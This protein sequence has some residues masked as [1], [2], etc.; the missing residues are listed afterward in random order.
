M[1]REATIASMTSLRSLLLCALWSFSAVAGA[2]ERVLSQ[3][4]EP[5]PVAEALEALGRQTG[6]QFIFVSSIAHAQRSKGAPAGLAPDAALA[7]LLDGTGLTFEFLNARTVRIFPAS[8]TVPT[9]AAPLPAPHHLSQRSALALEEVTVTATRREEVASRVPIDMMVWTQDAMEASGV[10]GMADLASLTPTMQFQPAPGTTGATTYLL[11]RGVTGRNASTTGVY[12]D[13]T[14]V[15]PLYGD[16]VLYSF[17]FTF[18]LDRVEVLRGPQLQLF[19]EGNQGGAVRFIFNQPSLST[20]TA[21]AK[22]ELATTRFGSPSYEA[23]A[24]FGGP[25]IRDAVGFRISAWARSDGGYVDRVDPFTQGV[26]DGNAN[27]SGSMS[28]RGAL[29]FAP[30]EAVQITPS[31][32]YT[33]YERHDQPYFFINLSDVGAGQLMNGSLL[34]QPANAAFYLGALKVAAVLGGVHFSAVSSYFNRTGY[35]LADDTS[36]FDWGSPL[37]SGYPVSYADA[38]ADQWHFQQRMFM[39]ELRL[40][41]PDPNATLT[42]H[43]GAFYSTYHVRWADHLTGTNGV[44]GLYPAP[45]DLS[46]VTS[47]AQTRLAVFG[48]VALRMTNRLAVS[49][50]V[51]GERT[52]YD[53]ENELAPLLSAAGADSGVMPR[54]RLAYQADEHELFYL[55]AGKGYGSGGPVAPCFIS[56]QASP[57][58]FGMDTLWSYEVGTKSTLLD[59]RMRLDTGLFHITWNNAGYLL[60]GP[61]GLPGSPGAAA[62]NGFDLAMQMLPSAHLQLDVDVAYTDARYTGTITQGGI[63]IVREGQAVN[64]S[65]DFVSVSPWTLTASVDYLVPLSNDVT[66]D[67]RAQDVFRSQNPGPFAQQDPQSPLY[68]PGYRPDPATNLVNLRASVRGG[69]YEAALFV[70]NAF[71]SLPTIQRFNATGVATTDRLDAATF[72]PRT[73][74]ASGTWRF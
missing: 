14:P 37:G 31:L 12:L 73:I 18:D 59:G 63:V 5:Q 30:S 8:V 22:S 19:G 34:R 58:V 65:S 74:G 28:L 16:V 17:P 24:A 72:R 45:T 47:G 41:S 40:T 48:E 15:P 49:A 35:F 2:A 33:S 50:A 13:D 11:M 67:F 20:F 23:G 10:K 64:T 26:V 71:N 62:S 51:H 52:S 42:W 1:A 4:I 39:Q 70:N 46:Q 27:H 21:F 53:A 29:T 69:R 61:C 57:E 7:E 68:A 38:V 32:T 3:A 54:L 25:V 36:A 43:A 9:P 44:P 66:V 56:N 55:T 60:A 6:L